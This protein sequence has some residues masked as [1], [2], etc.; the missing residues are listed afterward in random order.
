MMVRDEKIK[1]IHPLPIHL[2]AC[3][4]T[5]AQPGHMGGIPDRSSRRPEAWRQ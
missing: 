5:A 2:A 1:N 4:R 3:D